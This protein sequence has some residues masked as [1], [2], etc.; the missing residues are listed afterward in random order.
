MVGLA[1]LREL[2]VRRADMELNC[3]NCKCGVEL[4]YQRTLQHYRAFY[5]VQIELWRIMGKT[6]LNVGY[7]G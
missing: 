5:T 2:F 3:G 6:R 1:G 4:I 7:Q